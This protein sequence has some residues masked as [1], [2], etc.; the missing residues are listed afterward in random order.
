MDKSNLNFEDVY[1]E[2]NEKIG[3]YLQ[4]MVGKNDAEDV[5]QEVF[6]KIDKSLHGFKGKSSLSTWVYRIATNT[7]LEIGST[8]KF[9]VHGQLKKLRNIITQT[10]HLQIL[11]SEPSCPQ[12]D[13]R[14]F[15][16]QVGLL[17]LGNVR[18]INRNDFSI[19][20]DGAAN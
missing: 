2:F 12:Q 6:L 5:T 14:I 13:T 9:G 1:D 17:A 15:C 7:A 11:L 3:R 18:V 8:L 10:P 16:N 4:R 20:S 19:N